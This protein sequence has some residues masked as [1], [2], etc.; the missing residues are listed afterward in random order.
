MGI[1]DRTS[2]TTIFFLMCYTIP[3]TGRCFVSGLHA[4]SA[5]ST[6]KYC[7]FCIWVNEYLQYVYRRCS[8]QHSNIQLATVNER[9]STTLGHIPQTATIKRFIDGQ[10]RDA[11]SARLPNS[12]LSWENTYSERHVVYRIATPSFVAP[13]AYGCSIYI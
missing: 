1:P 4:T 13:Q 7:V 6:L 8:Q 3:S 5:T 2:F 9:I 10:T 12:R 11:T